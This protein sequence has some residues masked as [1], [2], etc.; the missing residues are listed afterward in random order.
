[1]QLTEHYTS[2][3][4]KTRTPGVVRGPLKVQKAKNCLKHSG[5]FLG[6]FKQDAR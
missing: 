4:N 1:M 2:A 5:R 3:I 6:K